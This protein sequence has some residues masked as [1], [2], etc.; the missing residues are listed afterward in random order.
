MRGGEVDRRLGAHGVGAARAAIRIGRRGYVDDC[1]RGEDGLGDGHG[2]WG[3][4]SESSGGEDEVWWPGARK[5]SMEL[6][7]LKDC[8]LFELL[9]YVVER[10]KRRLQFIVACDMMRADSPSARPAFES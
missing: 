6:E 2:G 7:G 10:R 9:R 8:G 1:L 5:Q 3:H 4:R